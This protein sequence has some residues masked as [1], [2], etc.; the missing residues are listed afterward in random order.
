[1][2]A[3][4]KYDTSWW[5]SKDPVEVA[6]YQTFEPTLLVDMNLYWSGVEKI[7]G[8]DVYLHEFGLNMEGLKNEVREGLARM[9]KEETLDDR[10][11][12]KRELQGIGTL[13]ARKSSVGAILPEE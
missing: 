11:A 2:D 8:R 5:E 12:T 9:E 1:M 4:K 6:R 7:V 10:V 3:M 13:T